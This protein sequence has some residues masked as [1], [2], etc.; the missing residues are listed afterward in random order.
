MTAP[1][2][3]PS[4]YLESSVIS[5][6]SNRLSRDYLVSAHQ[7]LTREWW[8]T[9]RTDFQIF[10]SSLV[11]EEI[12]QGDQEQASKRLSVIAELPI[13]EP[14]YE[15]KELARLYIARGAI[16]DVASDDALHMATASVKALDYL[17]SWNCKHIANERVRR[18]IE[19][20]NEECER[21]TPFICT[22]LELMEILGG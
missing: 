22:P 7:R 16:A 14:D 12:S 13:I 19:R 3:K 10:V 9:K 17:L 18:A 11:I 8:E 5:Y 4:V 21:P 15:A 20:L 2:E 6:L 1:I